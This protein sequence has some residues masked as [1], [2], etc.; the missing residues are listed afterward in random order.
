[1]KPGIRLAL[2][3]ASLA[4]SVL[5]CLAAPSVPAQPGVMK[6]IF[7]D[8]DLNHDGLIDLDEFHKDIV[9]SFAALDHNRDGYITEDEVT[10]LPDGRRAKFIFKEMLANADRDQDRRLSF[11]EVVEARMAY[12]DAADGDADQRLSLREVL[13]HHAAQA[14]RLAPLAAPSKR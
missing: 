8:A 11:K 13:D 7:V 1:M 6:Q 14:E 4:T 12:F 10:A 2:L 9:R 5:P 3:V